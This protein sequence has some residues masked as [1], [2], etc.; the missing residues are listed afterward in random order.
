MPETD[1]YLEVSLKLTIAECVLITDILKALHR[2]SEDKPLDVKEL[3]E[4]LSIATVLNLPGTRQRI[5]SAM[6]R[7]EQ[8]NAAVHGSA[9]ATRQ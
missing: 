2:A 3:L 9:S 4:T 6:D 7:A 8:I 5:L 1:A